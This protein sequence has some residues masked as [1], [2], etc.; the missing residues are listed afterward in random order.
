[1]GRPEAADGRQHTIGGRQKTVDSRQRLTGGRTME[2]ETTRRRY[3]ARA[4]RTLGRRLAF[5][6]ALALNFLPAGTLRANQTKP[7]ASLEGELLATGSKGP[8]LKT[9][10]KDQALSAVTPYLFRTLQD[11]RL[12]GRE[13]RVEGT[14]KPDG[15]FEVQWLYTIHQGKLFRVRYFCKVCNI[16]ALGPGHCVC[17][18]RPTELQE[19]PVEESGN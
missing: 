1:M 12:D 14:R 19:I 6:F 13:V 18:Q 2:R 9:R 16:V 7:L 10:D 11:K 17:C 3:S 5:A 15:T 8:A 4:S